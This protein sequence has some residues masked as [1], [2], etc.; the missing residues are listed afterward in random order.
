MCMFRVQSSIFP[1]EKYAWKVMR[2]TGKQW[3]TPYRE[4]AP[5]N[6][7]LKAIGS[8]Q[9]LY[10]NWNGYRELSGWAI[11]CFR[12]EAEAKFYLRCGLRLTAT[13]PFNEELQAWE[14]FKVVGKRPVAFNE[15]QI[16]FREIEFVDTINDWEIL[17]CSK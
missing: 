13:H 8:K 7:K 9:I 4:L 11:H 3:V 16:A 6:N 12:S 5:K 2:Y 14:I 1:K 10:N 15:S 17:L